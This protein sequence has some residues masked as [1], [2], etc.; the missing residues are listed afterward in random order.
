[1]KKLLILCLFVVLGMAA[2]AQQVYQEFDDATI[3]GDTVSVTSADVKYNG[4][5]TWDY[6]AVGVS[7]GDTCYI[8]FQGSNDGWTS[9]QTI[10]TTTFIQGTTTKDQHL[11]DDPSEYFNYRLYKRALASTDTVAFTNQLFIFKR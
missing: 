7:A 1:M 3:N 9:V 11:V 5:V 4:F 10:S 2:N 6:T 8:D